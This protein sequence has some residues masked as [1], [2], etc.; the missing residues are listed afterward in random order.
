MWFVVG[1]I[2]VP[3]SCLSC[4][5]HAGVQCWKWHLYEPKSTNHNPETLPFDLS[6]LGLCWADFVGENKIKK[7]INGRVWNFKVMIL[8]SNNFYFHSLCRWLLFCS[9]GENAQ[10]IQFICTGT[11]LIHTSKSSTLCQ[12][13]KTLVEKNLVLLSLIF[14]VTKHVLANWL[15][16]LWGF[17]S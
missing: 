1:G 15:R 9:P 8:K 4:L 17:K 12:H 11:C 3:L 16:L 14:Y 6:V 10:R 7:T 2:I 5:F 13:I